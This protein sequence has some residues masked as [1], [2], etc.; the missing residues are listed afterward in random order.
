MTK[1]DLKTFNASLKHSIEVGEV[2]KHD[3]TISDN[4]YTLP[5]A[6]EFLGV[7]ADELISCIENVGL[8][9][10]VDKNF[11]EFL[12]DFEDLETLLNEF[13]VPKRERETWATTDIEETTDGSF[14]HNWYSIEQAVAYL[15][16]TEDDLLCCVEKTA[17]EFLTN[18][19][20]TYLYFY[21]EDLQ[22]ILNDLV[23]P[24]RKRESR[25]TKSIDKSNTKGSFLDNWYSEEQAVAYLDI[26][27]DEFS[28]FVEISGIEYL[29]EDDLMILFFY[30]DDLDMIRYQYFHP[31][32]KS[33]NG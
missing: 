18:K 23:I 11:K 12:F 30:R 15:G 29:A 1:K 9:F 17:L 7:T 5:E 21:L 6:I 28:N 26:T 4:L 22:I 19:K 27:E 32:M 13:I 2:I 3:G 10:W 8:N 31:E 25:S 24:K 33:V 14:F 16:I 20:F